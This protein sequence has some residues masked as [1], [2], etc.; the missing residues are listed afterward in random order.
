LFAML[1][2]GKKNK[3]FRLFEGIIFARIETR[4]DGSEPQI[5]TL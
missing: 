2:L 3:N 4:M 1:H 5:Y